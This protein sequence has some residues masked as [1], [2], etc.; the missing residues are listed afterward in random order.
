LLSFHV[1]TAVNTKSSIMVDTATSC[2]LLDAVHH[3]P[4]D[5]T[6]LFEDYEHPEDCPPTDDTD[7]YDMADEN[8]PEEN[9]YEFTCV[10]VLYDTEPTT[11]F[12]F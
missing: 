6:Y 7:D 4:H 8:E 9:D 5:N 1:S 11:V 2:N 3:E 10:P 12:F